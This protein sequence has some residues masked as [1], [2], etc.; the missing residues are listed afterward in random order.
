MM[1][2]WT[3]ANQ[4]GGVGKTTTAVTIAGLMAQKGLRTLMIDLD[5]HGSMTSYF[6]YDPD[7]SDDNVYTLFQRGAAGPQ[8]PSRIIRETKFENLSLMPASTAL[9]TLDRQMGTQEGMGLVLSRALA[10]CKSEFDHVVIDCPPVLGV[11]MVNA[12]AAS[13][14]LLIPVQTEFLAIKGLERMLRTLKMILS[15]RKESLSYMIVPTMFDRRTRASVLSLKTI[16]ENYADYV[17]KWMIP[18]DTQ[19]RE[20]SRLGSPLSYLNPNARGVLAYNRLL[21]L[22]LKESPDNSKGALS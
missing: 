8:F 14:Y 13:R 19:F 10:L 17:W 11:L 6:G 1:Q 9:A 5:P 12:L 4:K 16:R 22:L 18:I 21:E 7:E 20:A 15:A 2:V 3:V